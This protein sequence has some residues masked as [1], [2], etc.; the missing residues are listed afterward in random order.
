MFSSKNNQ[1]DTKLAKNTILD[2]TVN[3][4]IDQRS[5]MQF[6]EIDD[7]RHKSLRI[8]LNISS[9]KLHVLS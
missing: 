3:K 8:L 2:P 9:F 6:L 4:F 1:T 5:L 7:F